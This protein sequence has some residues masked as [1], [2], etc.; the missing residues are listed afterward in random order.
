M[1]IL[2][3]CNI[4]FFI[5]KNSTMHFSPFEECA[6]SICEMSAYKHTDESAKSHGFRGNVGCVGH[7]IYVGC[8]GQIYFCVGL[9]VGKKFLRGSK[10]FPWIKFFFF[11]FAL[12]KFYLLDEIILIYYN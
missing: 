6:L 4:F 5:Q 1:Q 2:N 3:S 10:I 11:F 9:C 8:K 7:N 12:V